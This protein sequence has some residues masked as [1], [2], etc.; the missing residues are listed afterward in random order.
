ME[1]YKM[2]KENRNKAVILH[3]GHAVQFEME[4]EEPITQDMALEAQEKAGYIPAG[5]GFYAFK[6]KAYEHSEDPL[7]V[8]TWYCS[9]SCD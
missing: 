2:L 5:Y 6:T 8:A 1:G 7:Y 4:S 3:R 9:G